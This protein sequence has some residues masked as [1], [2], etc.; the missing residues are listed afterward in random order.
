MEPRL[1]TKLRP[2]GWRPWWKHVRR[3]VIIGIWYISG[4]PLWVLLWAAAA[5]DPALRKR[6]SLV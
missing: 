5:I 4:A 6:G 3:A 2:L 1:T